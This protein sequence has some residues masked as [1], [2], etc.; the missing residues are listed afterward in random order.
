MV[1]K[2]GGK[3]TCVAI[4]GRGEAKL[5][6][7]REGAAREHRKSGRRGQ[8]RCIHGE[9]LLGRGR[10]AR[11]TDRREERILE[12]SDERGCT[13]RGIP[14]LLSFFDK[15]SFSRVAKPHVQLNRLLVH[16]NFNLAIM[17]MCAKS[18]ELVQA[19]TT[20]SFELIS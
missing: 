12:S 3:R 6:S 5:C 9:A 11:G 19:R 1:R 20:F 2:E 7:G 16:L 14:Y 15:V 4:R 18:W 17:G 10:G 8:Q 13:T